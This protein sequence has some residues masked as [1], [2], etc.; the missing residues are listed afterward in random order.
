MEN[1]YHQEQLPLTFLYV[2]VHISPTITAHTN[3][4]TQAPFGGHLN[5]LYW[6]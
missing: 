5:H 6:T 2:P 4:G 3:S 1:C